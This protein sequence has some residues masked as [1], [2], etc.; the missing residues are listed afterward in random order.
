MAGI[1][2]PL[3]KTAQVFCVSLF[4]LMGVNLL[5][6]SPNIIISE[7][8]FNPNG[9]DEAR[10]F[11]EIKNVGQEIVELSGWEFTN[12]ILYTFPDQ[13][14]LEPG[15]F[16]VLVANAQFF[17][18][19]YPNVQIGGQ[20]SDDDGAG[21]G[22]AGLS[23]RGER[24][25]LKDGP[26]ETGSTIYSLRYYD[27]DDGSI[28]DP[29]ELPEDDDLERARWPSQPDGGDYSLVQIRSDGTSDEE[30]F[31]SWRPSINV[32][33]SP[34]EDEPLPDQLKKVF[35]NEMRT[36]DGLLSND[37][38]EIYNPNDQDVDISGWYISDNL[39]R[40]LKN[41]SII[42]GTIVPAG[43]YIVLENEING[44]SINLSSK[45]E[46]AFLYS[47][48]DGVLTGWVHGFH[49]PASIDGKHFSRFVDEYDAEYLIP[50]S[51][52]LG[53]DNGLPSPSD[54]NIVEIMYSPGYGSSVE[55]IKIVNNGLESALLY[56]SEYPDDN[57]NVN[58]F[59]MTLPGIRPIL[60]AGEFAYIT[61][62]S[63]EEFRSAYDI[64]NGVK[65]FADP[66]AGSLDG[67]GERI[68]LR[69]PLTI[70]GFQRD[71]LG[72][73][74]YYAILDALEYNDESPWPVEADGQGYSLVRKELNG[75]GYKASD[76]KL[77]ASRGGTAFGGPVVL[78]NEILSHTDL[79]Q[80]DVI[81]LYNPSPEPANIGGWYLTDN[82]LI[83]KKYRIPNG[84]VI[85]GNGYW[86]VNEDNNADAGA[87][88]NYFG[89]AFS[90]SSRG[91]EVFLFSANDEGL[92]TGYSHSAIFR[93]TENGVSIIRYVNGNGKEIFVPQSGTPTL[94]INRFTAFPDGYPNSTPLVEKAVISEICYDP[95][96]GGNEYI[97]ITNI[98]DGVLPLYDTTSLQQG[99]D[100]NNN[101]KLDGVTFIF[102]GVQPTLQKNER[103]LIIPKG[104]SV[105]QFK[106]NYLVPDSV[107]VF[108]GDEGYEGAL[109]NAGEEIVLLRP[110]KPDFVVGQGIVVP[111]IEVDSVNYDGGIEWPQ[112]EGRSIERINNLLVGNDS[113]N[114]QRSADQK[115]TPGAENS[116]QLNGFNLW[117]KNEFED[118]GII[119]QGTSST[120][121][122]DSDGITN[123]EEYA[124]GLNPREVS[125]MKNNFMVQNIKTNDVAFLSVKLIINSLPSDLIINL[126]SSSDLKNWSSTEEFQST[127]NQDGTTTLEYKQS[128][129]DQDNRSF[130]R[131]QIELIA[132]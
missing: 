44:F 12:G 5:R 84:T 80:T 15:Q 60:E 94:E 4:F 36:R 14:F 101:W 91:D 20:Y 9:P 39:D 11:I 77:S 43:G 31:R 53:E 1:L 81:E 112:G 27:G 95:F 126:L 51:S 121:D 98:S 62:T 79:P 125:T 19:Q 46:R 52:S 100:P 86:A 131:F 105:D 114:W 92:F 76:W 113:S 83:P 123:L 72:Y 10:E 115:G 111:M 45:G 47:A 128:N 85:P 64:E 41:S 107:R 25:T 13:T 109:N 69:L 102:P 93:A 110:D 61:N 73:P 8:H 71:A 26:D 120:D 37:A 28:P 65:V 29:P 30:D 82:F 7:I 50:D 88:L 21:V 2:S 48:E 124:F 130:Y 6:A 127:V 70:E 104:V 118:N 119:G 90:L 32:H 34:G 78:I 132:Q 59:G 56:D 23:N 24:V 58:G 35:I 87:P 38:I 3:S 63:E 99:G 67:G 106:I 116:V 74:R 117:L 42:E 97:E 89:T 103:V 68:E 49:F 17:A 96:I 57:L 55:Y 108:G 33:G 122:Y 22:R 16:F 40:P 75:A 54:I 18:T 129:L 66:E